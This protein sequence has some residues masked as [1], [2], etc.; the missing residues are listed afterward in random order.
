MV[1]NASSKN[2]YY[3]QKGKSMNI[4]DV[5]TQFMHELESDIESSI[6]YFNSIR[7]E[8]LGTTRGEQRM[9]SRQW[10]EVVCKLIKKHYN[11]TEERLYCV[12]NKNSTPYI[13]FDKKCVCGH[14]NKN[15]VAYQN[16]LDEIILGNICEESLKMYLN[17]YMRQ[18]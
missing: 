2:Y 10:G 11:L 6:E 18:K 12:L 3:N 16:C 5:R 8:K 14:L 9:P 17:Y 13:G 4:A 1:V 15:T 7:R